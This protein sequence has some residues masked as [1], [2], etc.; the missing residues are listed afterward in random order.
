MRKWAFILCI[1]GLAIL[2]FQLTFQTSKTINS[3]E[4]FSKLTENQKV[5]ASGKVVEEKLSSANAKTY[6]LDNEIQILCNLD[7]PFYLNKSIS[8]IGILDTFQ[9]PRIKALQIQLK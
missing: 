7:C 9:K 8:V 6:T 4:E 2:L 3:P 5:Q 1:L